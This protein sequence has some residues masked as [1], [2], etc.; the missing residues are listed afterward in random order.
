M[1]NLKR[2]LADFRGKSSE[3]SD[4]LYDADFDALLI[5][6]SIATQYG[7]LPADQGELPYSEWAKLVSGLMDNTPLGKVVETRGETD[8]KV[9][10]QM[11]PW[12]KRIRAEWQSFLAK[13]AV[14]QPRQELMAQMAN[15]E[16]MFAKAFGGG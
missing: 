15:L 8:P 12:Q 6:Q 7:I 9:I 3:H 2:L 13:K 4:A 1:K 16:A 5:E 10:A 11:G 14:Q